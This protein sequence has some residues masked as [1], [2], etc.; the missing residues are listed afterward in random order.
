MQ[1]I[2]ALLCL[3]VLAVSGCA[4]RETPP[5]GEAAA[6]PP[7]QPVPGPAASGP[8]I[9]EPPEVKPHPI[10]RVIGFLKFWDRD[11]EPEAPRAALPVWVGIVRLVNKDS[12]FVLIENTSAY[13]VP[14]GKELTVV[15]TGR[16][17]A[18]LKVTEDRRHPFFLADI[19]SGD[20]RVGER[21]YSAE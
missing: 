12:G 17:E 2:V 10:S 9:P 4:S 16:G 6:A 7:Q 14:P 20:P 21:V 15:T 18:R 13:L 5:E 19:V 1:K 11:P 3:L 8:V